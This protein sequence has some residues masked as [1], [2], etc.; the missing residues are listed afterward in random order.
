MATSLNELRG[1]ADEARNWLY[2]TAAPLWSTTGVHADGL[3]NEAIDKRGA[4]VTK[5]RRMKVQARQIY[6]FCELGRLGWQGPWREVAERAL[7]R[8]ISHTRRTDGLFVHEIAPD[9][10]VADDRA[11]LMDHAFILFALAYAASALENRTYITLAHELM[12]KIEA[13]WANRFGGFD[14]GDVVSAVPRRQNPHMHMFEAM[15]ALYAASGEDRWSMGAE[16]IADLGARKFIDS[17]SGALREYFTAQ[18]EPID[19]VDGR[20][21]EPGHCFEWAWLL[22]RDPANAV[23]TRLA[24]GLIH[25][26]RRNGIDHERNVAIY[27]V[28]IDGTPKDRSARL[29]AQTERLKAALARW[30]RINDQKEA[31]EAAAAFRGLKRYLETPVKGSWWDRLLPDNT[32]VDEPAPASSF[33]HIVCAFSELIGTVA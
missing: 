11:D 16:A 32:F 24:D 13:R 25:F 22:Q 12:D 20:T 18:W 23:R 2:D 9:G 3:F 7:A 21:I 4:C 29:W 27:E 26:A 1:C 5:S 6:C 30:R 19:G 8:L 17:K 28:L 10:S 15:L 33:Y 14:E 31:Q